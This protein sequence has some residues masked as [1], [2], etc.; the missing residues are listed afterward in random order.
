VGGQKETLN[1]IVNFI[2]GIYFL[3]KYNYHEFGLQGKPNNERKLETMRKISEISKMKI[4]LSIQNDFPL[5]R[6]SPKKF[7]DRV[8][9]Q[10]MQDY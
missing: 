6:R 9:F 7:K 4:W 8:C 1:S 10:L 2:A 5:A 3:S